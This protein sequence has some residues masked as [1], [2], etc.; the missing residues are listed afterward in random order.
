M[1]LCP[2]PLVL[3]GHWHVACRLS[4]E[5]GTAVTAPR[6][7][8]LLARRRGAEADRPC[9]RGEV[10]GEATVMVAG[11]R[12]GASVELV[13]WSPRRRAPLRI[14][15]KR[16]RTLSEVIDP[17]SGMSRSRR[18]LVSRQPRVGRGGSWPADGGA[19]GPALSRWR[20]RR[21]RLREGGEGGGLQR[22]HRRATGPWAIDAFA[23]RQRWQAT[24][25]HHSHAAR[26]KAS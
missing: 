9:P 19:L 26:I 14:P 12:G 11:S 21:R 6:V 10:R 5:P 13:E 20:L 24:V 18:R 1:R 8:E 7:A 25:L 16:S 23:R 2:W 22:T 17:S 3:H 15:R 4:P